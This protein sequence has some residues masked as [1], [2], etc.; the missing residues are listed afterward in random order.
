MSYSKTVITY[1]TFDLL[2]VGHIRLLS[3]LSE[4]GTR[5]IV[6]VSTDEHNA[7]KGKTSIYSFEERCEILRACRFVDD[8]FPEQD[9]WAQKR[10][11]MIRFRAD[12]CAMGDDW[13][14]RFDFLADLC[15]V[16]YLPRTEGIS[17]SL[18]K[19]FILA[20]GSDVAPTTH[21]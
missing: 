18:T 14:G 9:F 5:V 16:V 20:R 11:E 8:I 17:T 19:E 12:I 13:I 10:D 1:G 6:G 7:N 2:H 15:Q 4:L 3:R 21:Q